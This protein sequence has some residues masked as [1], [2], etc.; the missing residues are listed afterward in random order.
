[1]SSPNGCCVRMI[2]RVYHIDRTDCK[3]RIESKSHE[4]PAV[5]EQSKFCISRMTFEI[6][7]QCCQ[8]YGFGHKHTAFWLVVWL[9]G[10]MLGRMQNI[11]LFST[12]VAA[13]SKIRLFAFQL[14]KLIFWNFP[15]WKNNFFFVIPNYEQRVR[16][17]W[18]SVEATQEGG[19]VDPIIPNSKLHLHMKE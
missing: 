2:C 12:T 8:V 1:M 15:G 7:D 16:F 3:S 9:Y 10:P 14:W 18:W 6:F 11:Q 4:G 13:L 19:N 5:C 17:W